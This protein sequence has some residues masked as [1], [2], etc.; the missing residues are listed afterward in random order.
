MG[1]LGEREDVNVTVNDKKV[2]RLVNRKDD[3]D[4]ALKMASTRPEVIA[5]T[6]NKF[7]SDIVPYLNPHTEDDCFEAILKYLNADATV[8]ARRYTVFSEILENNEIGQFLAMTFL[9]AINRPNKLMESKPVAD[10]FPLLD[11]VGNECPICRKKLTKKVKGVTT[12][13]YGIVEIFPS[14]L[15]DDT[16]V[17]FENALAPPVKLNSSDNQIALCRTHAETYQAG[18]EIDEYLVLSSLK[19]QFA[20][21]Y[22][23]QQMLADLNL[24]DEIKEVIDSL[25]DLQSVGTL[26]T[27]SMTAL[28]ID[29]KIL[30]E[31]CLL[32]N[33]I[34]NS[35]LTY[36]KYIS[37]LFEEIDDFDIIQSEI[38]KAFK[39]L[40]SGD[41]SQQE[42]VEKLAQWI[43]EQTKRPAQH[44]EACRIIV[45]FFVQSCEVFN[46]ISK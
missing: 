10:D 9:Y 33:A 2:S 31:N 13:Q 14:N 8:P 44:I 19:K 40:N 5:D 6:I 32:K 16:A 12:R 25:A 46:E 39:E 30:P 36:Y 43:L 29:Q 28:K 23:L 15:D 1:F 34:Q 22:A 4:D 35:V 38:K 18:P 41:W 11:E 7:E 45:A 37:A 26:E 3:V 27:L 20:T 17:D 42:I 21:D 24:E